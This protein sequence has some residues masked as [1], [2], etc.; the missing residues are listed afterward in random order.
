[1]GLLGSLGKLIG[2]IFKWIVNFVKK[3]LAIILTIVIIVCLIYFAPA[4][5]GW[6]GSVGA[7]SWLTTAFTW[8]GET[9]TPS[10]ISGLSSCWSGISSMFSSGWTS[11]SNATLGTKAAI[12][13][14][15]SAAIAPSETAA[16]ISDAAGLV[17]STGGTF[18]SSLASSPWGVTV[19]A[20]AVWW[21][22]FRKK[23]EDGANPEPAGGQA[24]LPVPPIPGQAPA[25]TQEDPAGDLRA[26]PITEGS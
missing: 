17:V 1:M 21:F 16:V 13:S 2:A 6:L 23:G 7:P 26:P 12:V 10:L 20:G 24:A 15:L 8:V 22:F 3:Y 18:L 19:I 4:I 11:F 5:A 25:V 9:I 14:G